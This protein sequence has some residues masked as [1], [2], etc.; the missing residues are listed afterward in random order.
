MPIGLL[1]ARAALVFNTSN[2]PEMRER[3]VFG[4]P[5]EILWKNC[6]FDFCG[7]QTFFRR[8]FSVVVTSS[9]EQRDG[10]AGEVRPDSPEIFPGILAD[11][12]EPC[13]N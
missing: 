7:V 3:E 6:I 1:K 5:L 4:D 13:M 12:R 11:L 8:M 9:S 10:L 2:T